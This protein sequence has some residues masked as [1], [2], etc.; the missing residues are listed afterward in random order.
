GL[1]LFEEVAV[2]FTEEEWALLDPDQRA[3]HR[4]I[5]EENCGIVASLGKAPSSLNISNIGTERVRRGLPGHLMILSMT[6]RKNTLSL[7]PWL[8]R[9]KGLCCYCHQVVSAL[10]SCCKL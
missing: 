8:D 4:Q 9:G 10:H 6:V 2:C 1:V 7:F 3:L 5:M